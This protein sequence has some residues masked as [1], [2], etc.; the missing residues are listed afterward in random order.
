M[1]QLLSMGAVALLTSALLDPMIKWG[2]DQPI[3][4][5]RDLGMAAAGIV[6]LYIRVKYRRE[7]S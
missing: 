3:P 2:L 7:L 1:K 6:C 4:W 5:G